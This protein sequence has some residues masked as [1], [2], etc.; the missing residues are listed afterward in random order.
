MVIDVL[1]RI[2]P[3]GNMNRNA[4][5]WVVTGRL[6]P[7]DGSSIQRDNWLLQAASKGGW[8][9]GQYRWRFQSAG[10]ERFENVH[11]TKLT[12]WPGQCG[13]AGQCAA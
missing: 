3:P 9:G 8:H 13:A 4:Y 5:A 10:P 12:F 6:F 1:Q 2:K 7:A 11:E